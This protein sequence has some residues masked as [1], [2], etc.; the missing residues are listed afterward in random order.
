MTVV[1]LASPGPVAVPRGALWAAAA[2]YRFIE[3]VESAF[4][5]A[6]T[7]K[8]M[9]TRAS[10][11]RRARAM[12]ERLAEFDPRVAREVQIAADRLLHVAQ[13]VNQRVGED[14]QQLPVFVEQPP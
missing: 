13:L 4:K 8:A 2:A 9:H 11:A 12:A 10:Q 6:H 14:R 3:V 7:A 1:S 5:A